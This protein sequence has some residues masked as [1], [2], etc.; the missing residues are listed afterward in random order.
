LRRGGNESVFRNDVLSEIGEQSL[1]QFVRLISAFL[2]TLMA[3]NAL[4]S[5]ISLLELK[6]AQD[7]GC[8]ILALSLTNICI[9][10]SPESTL[11]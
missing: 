10:A 2:A 3:A 11:C 9:V 6:E 7:D 1:S 8:I 5:P 4:G